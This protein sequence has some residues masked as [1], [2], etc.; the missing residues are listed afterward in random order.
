MRRNKTLLSSVQRRCDRL[1]LKSRKA[2]RRKMLA[3]LRAAGRS[4]DGNESSGS[5][6]VETS[7]AEYLRAREEGRPPRRDLVP[8][9]P[10]SRPCAPGATSMVELTF[11]TTDDARDDL[12]PG[13]ALRFCSRPRSE[14]TLVPTTSPEQSV[15][16][17]KKYV[18]CRDRG[19]SHR[20]C[21]L[22]AGRGKR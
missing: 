6:L 10:S 20:A 4:L 1:K 18:R 2:C 21:L 14:G 8:M 17:A 16:V 11:V 7:L 19:E 13:P 3:S 9:L 5:A 22:K 12:S 15:D